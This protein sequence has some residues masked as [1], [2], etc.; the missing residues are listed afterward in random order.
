MY[1]DAWP[2][3]HPSLL[4]GG[5]ALHEPSYI[6]LWKRLDP[7]PT[8]EEVIRNYPVRQPILWLQ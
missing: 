1:F 7:D 6:A 5:R 3:R 8:V 4:F 2:I